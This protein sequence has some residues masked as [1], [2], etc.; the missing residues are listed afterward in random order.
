MTYNPFTG[1]SIQTIFLQSL[2]DAINQ[3]LFYYVFVYY[4]VPS[5]FQKRKYLMFAGGFIIA[6]T[7]YALV[8][9]LSE[10]YILIKCEECMQILK[11]GKTGYYE[12]LQ[13]DIGGRMFKKLASLGILFGLIF[14]I[15]I[16]LSIKFFL[17]AF[18]R[19]LEAAHLAKQ[20]VEM[21]F[22]FLKSQLNPHF[23]FNTLNNIYGLILNN[24][25][26]KAAGIVARL[27]E[28]M[29]YTLYN[30][31][32]DKMPINK[33]IQLL[34]DY[35]ELESIRLNYNKVKL[36]VQMDD[37]SYSLPSLLLMPVIENAFKY[38][39]DNSDAY[40]N[41]EFKIDKKAMHFNIENTVDE[42][43]QLNAGGGIG[44][45]NLKKRLSLYYPEKYSYEV[46]STD[47][48]YAVKLIIEL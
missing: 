47:S 23:L 25:N 32:G 37:H 40:I 24:E 41:I 27:S 17:Q 35:I 7:I 38:S 16:P 20:N 45:Q 2:A 8:N 3:A 6:I 22:N 18:R 33:E 44:L 21:E 28:F 10:S 11:A 13:D 1:F 14:P 12:F 48:I 42:N 34:K 26:S 29:R 30:S 39:S 31:S 9:S 4:L 15:S 5:L 46:Q 19:Q 43:K 36:N